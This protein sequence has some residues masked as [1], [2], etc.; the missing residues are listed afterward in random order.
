MDANATPRFA[1]DH[2]P[3]GSRCTIP[4]VLY[5][6]FTER[7]HAES[8]VHSGEFR[9]RSLAYYQSEEADAIR[10]DNNEG[11]I[12]INVSGGTLTIRRKDNDEYGHPIT[13]TNA[14]IRN[15]LEYAH[16]YFASCYSTRRH[17]HHKKF[18]RWLVR[19]H[20]PTELIKLLT[21]IE[22]VGRNLFWGRVRYFD[23]LNFH[24]LNSHKQLWISKP[25]AFK[26]EY[27][28]RLL[29]IIQGFTL[30]QAKK[31]TAV[32][33]TDSIAEYADIIED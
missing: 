20:R 7:A 25:I 15:K 13:L 23:P 18:G 6:R 9:F 27:E 33:Q 16:L 26:L 1:I 14:T 8:F 28:F 17:L 22:P 2:A 11:S 31:G 24:D 29:L 3:M 21:T 12:T 32:I 10:R 5:R 4:R 30:Q 19:I